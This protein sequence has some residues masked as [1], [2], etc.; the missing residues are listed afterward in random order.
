MAITLPHKF[1]PRDYQV[2][3]FDAME[4]GYRRAVMV[5]H[6]RGG[7]DKTCLNIMISK[8]PQ[9]KGAYYYYFP[10]LSLGRKILWDGMDKAGMKFM[11]HF[12][13]GMV[14]KSNEHEMKL[15]LSGGSTFQ[16]LG[17]DRLDVVG[18]NPV[19]CVFSE[20]AQQD[21]RVWDF[22]RPILTENKI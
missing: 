3:I 13:R 6:R 8:I 7:K 22:I 12:P 1:V 2:P 14:V 20:Y 16:I 10:T 19:G 5:M 21:P 17:T 18:V 4:S 15:L 9:R 11:D